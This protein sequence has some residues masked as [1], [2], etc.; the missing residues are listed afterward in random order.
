M[1]AL[2]ETEL[3]E[4]DKVDKLKED[5]NKFVDCYD[6]KLTMFLKVRSMILALKEKIIDPENPPAENTITVTDLFNNDNDKNLKQKY[7]KTN[8][9][10]SLLSE[11][12]YIDGCINALIKRFCNKGLDLSNFPIYK[13]ENP[14]SMFQTLL[15]IIISDNNVTKKLID[16]EMKSTASSPATTVDIDSP[17]SPF[18]SVETKILDY[19]QSPML[20][21][22]STIGNLVNGSNT[23]LTITDRNEKLKGEINNIGSNNYH[24]VHSASK[25]WSLFR[26]HYNENC[27]QIQ[28]DIRIQS[29][30]FDDT[31]T[32]YN[33]KVRNMQIIWKHVILLKKRRKELHT[34]LVNNT[35]QTP[36]PRNIN[37]F[38]SDE[39]NAEEKPFTTIHKYTEQE[40]QN[41]EQEGK[42]PEQ[43]KQN[44]K[45]KKLQSFIKEMSTAIVEPPST[46]LENIEVETFM[47]IPLPPK[48]VPATPKTVL[49]TQNPLTPED[50]AI[51]I[52]QTLEQNVKNKEVKDPDTYFQ[53][54]R[55]Q[56][57]LAMEILLQYK[58]NK[59][60]IDNKFLAQT[61]AL[62]DDAIYFVP[63][64]NV[65]GQETQDVYYYNNVEIYGI[66]DKQKVAEEFLYP[67]EQ[68]AA[69]V[70]EAEAAEEQPEAA[71]EEA[72]AAEQQKQEKQK[73][74]KQEKILELLDWM[75]TNLHVFVGHYDLLRNNLEVIFKYI[76]H[77]NNLKIFNKEGTYTDNTNEKLIVDYLKV[78]IEAIKDNNNDKYDILKKNVE[79]NDV[80][81]TKEENGDIVIKEKL[82]DIDELLD[83]I[84][85]NIDNI[86]KGR[87]G[88]PKDRNVE[89]EKI[90][91]TVEL[92]ICLKNK[93]QAQSQAQASEAQEKIPEIKKAIE[94]LFSKLIEKAK[95]VNTHVF[96]FLGKKSGSDVR[97]AED[98]IKSKRKDIIKLHQDRSMQLRTDLWTLYKYIS[99]DHELFVPTE[100]KYSTRGE[101]K[102]T[103]I[104]GT[105][106]KISAGKH[107]DELIM[108]YQDK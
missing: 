32:F 57:Y 81:I 22:G 26:D 67:K 78:F 56:H 40:E 51:T 97:Y 31:N 76:H 29:P 38:E 90:N 59:Q 77:D 5:L 65:G 108:I 100:L 70:P 60:D 37:I 11:R 23:P 84:N 44:P 15:L 92:L 10:P 18:S 14:K 68:S 21:T 45:L 25:F 98:Q 69:Q 2:R 74:K 12:S 42:P 105:W 53:N 54:I 55:K 107:T 96:T 63:Q 62:V 94:K 35:K 39:I 4:V 80:D 52:V 91:D 1:D 93:A 88:E 28:E 71:A 61:L 73:Q 86:C 6:K 66:F 34:I 75:A 27:K 58:A 87:N 43:E 103:E 17:S 8:Q 3:K 99:P 101:Q 89:F 9:D 102:I 64:I 50:A 24:K 13:G 16:E 7:M 19:M 85:S 83:K 30:A 79:N 106:E 46:A 95:C 47:E 48:Y 82:L 41:T 49:A 20:V 104:I 36:L 33:Q 72:E